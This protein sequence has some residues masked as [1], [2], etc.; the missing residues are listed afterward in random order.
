MKSD[1]INIHLVGI[2]TSL[3]SDC[4]TADDLAKRF[5]DRFQSGSEVTTKVGVTKLY[6]FSDDEDLVDVSV[7]TAMRLLDGLGIKL[8]DING[9]FG[10]SNPTSETLLPTFTTMVTAKMGLTNVISDHVGIGCAGG[11]QALRAAYNQLVVD[12]LFNKYSY[13]LVIIGDQTIRM[14][15]PED[16]KTALLFSESVVALILTN[17]PQQGYKI[18]RIGTKTLG[19]SE[20]DVLRLN[21]P[22]GSRQKI[23]KIMMEG[24]GVYKF[25]VKI[26]P[27]ILGLIDLI[28]IPGKT[29]F[30]PHQANLR[31]LDAMIQKAG[32]S[33]DQVYTNGIKTIGNTSQSAVFF[34]LADALQNDLFDKNYDVILGAFGAE[35]Q[36]GGV[37]LKP[38][39]DKFNLF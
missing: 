16:Y 9:V 36:I 30:I 24:N 11:I 10:I 23:E 29:Y 15:D 8:N 34:G 28:E 25:G 12:S 33:Y 21:N 17:T 19:G 38:D 3:G 2:A 35:L 7:E 27:H 6:K 20:V 5:P 39:F 26:L 13:Y 4:I 31:M 32:L 18:E 37:L 1:E 22:Y 14:M